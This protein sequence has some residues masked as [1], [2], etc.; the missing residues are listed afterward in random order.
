MPTSAFN[1]RAT[2]S[3]T[4]RQEHST[5][6]KPK[7]RARRG[8]TC[9][10][11]SGIISRRTIT[12]RPVEPMAPTGKRRLADRKDYNLTMSNSHIKTA[13]DWGV[14]QA[15][16]QVG[17]GSV[18]DLVKEA[19][20]IGLISLDKTAGLSPGAAGL[21]LTPFGLGPVGAGFAADDGH[22]LGAAAGHM[23]GGAGGAIGG[24]LAGG[25]LGTLLGAL[26]KNP[27]LGGE[28]GAGL[29]A[30]AGGGYGAYN[31]A[32]QWGQDDGLLARAKR[33]MGG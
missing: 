14:Q 4:V 27:T 7:A 29:G 18:E 22:A 1:P 32:N 30:L 17:Y 3:A 8:R 16:S 2:K 9:R 20:A 5:L 28:I 12:L 15:L 31:L 26:A 24:G 13:H 33:G 23:L 6:L 11:G 10:T 21:A 25:A 19:A